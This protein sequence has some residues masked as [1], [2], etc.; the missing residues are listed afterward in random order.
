MK[1]VEEKAD[2]IVDLISAMRLGRRGGCVSSDVTI[3]NFSKEVFLYVLRV[4]GGAESEGSEKDESTHPSPPL[5]PCLLD[6]ARE[7]EPDAEKG[8]EN[9]PIPPSPLLPLS[10]EAG[11]SNF[12]FNGGLLII[13][14]AARTTTSFSLGGACNRTYYFC[15]AHFEVGRAI[16]GGLGADLRTDPAELVPASPI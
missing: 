13:S 11:N 9:S 3:P 14:S 8:L 4:K 2:E 15:V 7:N 5:S 16:R 12:D 6:L 1:R 10:A